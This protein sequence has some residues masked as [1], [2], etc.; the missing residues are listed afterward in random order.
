M[1]LSEAHKVCKKRNALVM[2]VDYLY[3]VLLFYNMMF[4]YLWTFAMLVIMLSCNLPR[5]KGR[6]I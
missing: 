6:T 4:V 1:L 3:S 5:S 2:T